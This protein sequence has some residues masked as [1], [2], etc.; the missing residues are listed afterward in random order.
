VKELTD[1]LLKA[2]VTQLDDQ[3]KPLIEKWSDP[4]TALQVLEVLDRCVEGALASGFVVAVLQA[5]YDTRCKA[6]GITH[7]ELVKQATWRKRAGT[8][9]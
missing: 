7:E 9:T 8:D 5:V 4:P 2:S 3:M 1:L 6:D